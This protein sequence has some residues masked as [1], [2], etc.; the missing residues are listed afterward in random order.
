MCTSPPPIKNGD[1]VSSAVSTYENGSS[2]EYQCFDNHFLQGSKEAY[3]VDGVWTT[4]PLCL[5]M[6]LLNTPL[7]HSAVERCHDTDVTFYFLYLFY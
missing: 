7:L 5:G 3:C 6:C 2:V 1:I 4:P